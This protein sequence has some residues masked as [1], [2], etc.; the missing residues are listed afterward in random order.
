[1]IKS[2]LEKNENKKVNLTEDITIYTG[3]NGKKVV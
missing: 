2:E 1:M 3:S